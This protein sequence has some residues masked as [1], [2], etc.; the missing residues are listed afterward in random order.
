MTIALT[1]SMTIALSKERDFA[2]GMVIALNNDFFKKNK[3][4][5]DES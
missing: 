2:E 4:F 1:K 5:F 3:K